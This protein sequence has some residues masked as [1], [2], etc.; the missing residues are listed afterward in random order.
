[1]LLRVHYNLQTKLVNIKLD[2]RNSLHKMKCDELLFPSH[3]TVLNLFEHKWTS[4]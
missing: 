3:L 1:M 2:F 4:H